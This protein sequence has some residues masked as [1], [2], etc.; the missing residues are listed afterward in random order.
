MPKNKELKKGMLLGD[1]S[2][3]RKCLFLGTIL[4]KIQVATKLIYQQVVRGFKFGEYRCQR[5]NDVAMMA[6]QQYYVEN[7]GNLEP[8][9]L[10]SLLPNYLPE[11]LVKNSGDKGLYRWGTLVTDAFNKS[12]YSKENVCQS[13][14]K[15]RCG[16]HLQ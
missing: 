2:L 12:Y 14:S 10:S 13:E 7:G 3:G 16:K 15:G 11:Q 9:L 6:A 4:Q 8:S 1:Y 5:E